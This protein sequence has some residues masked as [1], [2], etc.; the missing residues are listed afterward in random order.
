MKATALYEFVLSKEGAGQSSLFSSI[1]FIQ[2][3]SR[4]QFQKCQPI[5]E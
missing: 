5:N 3:W 2:M 1:P 4:D